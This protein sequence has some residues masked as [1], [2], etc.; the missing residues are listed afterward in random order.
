MTME[1]PRFLLFINTTALINLPLTVY[2]MKQK[3]SP[4][5]WILLQID[6]KK[7]RNQFSNFSLRFLVR[8]YVFIK[9]LNVFRTV[10]MY[11]N[12]LSTRVSILYWTFLYIELWRRDSHCLLQ[13]SI[14]KI[15]R[16]NV[17][18]NNANSKM[19]MLIF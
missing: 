2:K 13:M 9:S 6:L 17:S 7:M 1:L 5:Q 18:E 4:N 10:T 3:Q 19:A 12:D 8:A 15:L 11:N 16:R 14:V